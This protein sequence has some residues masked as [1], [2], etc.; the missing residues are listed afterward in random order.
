MKISHLGMTGL[1]LLPIPAIGTPFADALERLSVENPEFVFYADTRKSFDTGG[2]FLSEL[3]LAY[4]AANPDTPPIPVNVT[5][6]FAHFGLLDLLDLTASSEVR[7]AGGFTNQ[8]LYRFATAPDGLFLLFGD[9]NQPFRI[10]DRAPA[11]S[12]LVAELNFNGMALFQ[13]IRNV[14]TD[15]MGE[16]GRGLLEA[17]MNTPLMENGPTLADLITRLTTRIE[18]AAKP[19]FSHPEAVSSRRA[20]LDGHLAI[21]VVNIADLME[22]FAPMLHQMG[23]LPVELGDTP[24]WK[25]STGSEASPLSVF[26]QAMKGSNDLLVSFREDTRTWLTGENP[27]I[28]SSDE[29]KR[30]TEGLSSSGTAF[31]YGSKRMAQL[32]VTHMDATFP[33][34][35]KYGPM[36]EVLKKQLLRYT[37]E[38]AGVTLL[39]PDAFRVINY[40]P[41]SYKTSMILAAVSMP[42]GMAAGMGPLIEQFFAKEPTAEESLENEDSP[43]N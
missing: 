37:G 2:Q 39:E 31:W 25:L 10:Q 26:L 3:Y 11:D 6:L 13:I 12:D 17:Q 34:K 30:I 28:A 35:D 15:I 19:D 42:V 9:N 27:S 20:F 22:S 23:F 21:R 18:I 40:Q 14:M 8:I 41:V 16:M 29:F 33:E 7:P 38:Q 32:Q 5:R 43:A 1:L 24:G 36:L 4:L